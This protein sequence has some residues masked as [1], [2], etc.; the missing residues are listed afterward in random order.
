M[1]FLVLN[2]DSF[3]YCLSVFFHDNSKGNSNS[4]STF[5]AFNLHLLTLWGIIP[6]KERSIII[7]PET[8]QKDQEQ[9]QKTRVGKPLHREG[10]ATYS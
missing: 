10:F 9:D 2:Y 8:S 7:K 4:N 1:I 5:I 3:V 6:E